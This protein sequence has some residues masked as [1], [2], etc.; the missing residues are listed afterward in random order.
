MIAPTTRRIARQLKNRWGRSRPRRGAE[1]KSKDELER[2]R[3][4][5]EQ[6]KQRIAD[7]ERRLAEQEKEHEKKIGENEKKIADLERQLALHRRNSTNSSKPPSS[8][9][10]A[11]EQ[12]LRGCRQKRRKSRRKAGGQ[13]GHPGHWRPLVPRELVNRVVQLFPDHCGRCQRSLP[14]DAATRVTTG[15]P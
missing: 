1:F 8:D 15:E 10:L 13:K 11:G 6:R 3:E 7:L 5:V 14:S 2:L 12:R 4:E 9:G